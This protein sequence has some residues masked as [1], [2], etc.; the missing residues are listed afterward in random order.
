MIKPKMLKAG[1]KVAV[2]SLS[3]GSIGESKNISRFEKGKEIFEN[4][5]GLEVVVMPNALKGKKW[6]KEHPEL[7]AKDLMD[8]FK[9]DSIKA[10]F[11]LTGGDDTIRLLPYIDYETIKSNPKIFMGYSDTT[12]NH[13]MM[14]KSGVVSYYGPAVAV[15][16]S[17]DENVNQN[18]E[19]VL[20]TL[21]EYNEQL[22]LKH[23][24]IAAN[25][26]VDWSIRKLEY[27]EDPKGYE[28]IQGNRTVSGCLLGGCLEVFIMIN[29]TE[30]WPEKDEWENK[31]L[32]L[33]VSDET[34]TPDFVKWVL[35][36]LGV[37]GVLS[38]IN[39][40]IFGRTKN[41]K[42]YEEYNTVL[43]EV[44]KQFGSESLPILANAHFGHAWLWNILP[45]G[46][47]VQLDC[48]NKTLKILESPVDKY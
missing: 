25:D 2:V 9:D 42:Y 12:V 23:Y 8:A 19:S 18:I 28:V 35:T 46:C 3:S 40:I 33:E 31:I 27:I 47:N 21:F 4:I 24:N 15:E 44:T 26:P 41:G 37:Q 38:K 36:N 1:D 29:G 5:F 11:T 39:G 34:T 43:K 32:F 48:D 13:F 17:L 10:I 22:E 16:F 20:K 14:Y 30:I 7:R 45:Y 6:V